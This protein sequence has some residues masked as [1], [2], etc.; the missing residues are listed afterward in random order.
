MF[1]RP[2]TGAES[3]PSA[4]LSS[5]DAEQALGLVRELSDRVSK[6]DSEIKLVE[7]EIAN[8][9]ELK[10]AGEEART[11]RAVVRKEVEE[12]I[13]AVDDVKKDIKVLG[14]EVG[15]VK[16]EFDRTREDLVGNNGGLAQVQ[17]DVQALRDKQAQLGLD[18]VKQDVK[19]VKVAAESTKGDL[20]G[21]KTELGGLSRD[22]GVVR[23]EVDKLKKEVSEKVAAAPT[24]TSATFGPGKRDRNGVGRGVSLDAMDVDDVPRPVKRAR[25]SGV[26]APDAPQPAV[27]LGSPAIIVPQGPTT[28]EM[29]N[30]I[31]EV[32]DALQSLEN[33][34]VQIGADV[35][36]RLDEFAVRLGIPLDEDVVY[37]IIDDVQTGTRSESAPPGSSPKINIVRAGRSSAPPEIT[38]AGP[39]SRRPSL[40]AVPEAPGGEDAVSMLRHDLDSLMGQMVKL[41]GSEGDWPATINKNLCKAL[42]VESLDMWVKKED[43]ERAMSLSPP[44]SA[45]KPVNGGAVKEEVEGSLGS[46]LKSIREDQASMRE[47]MEKMQRERAEDLNK[48]AGL[49]ERLERSE[50]ALKD[51]AKLREELEKEHLGMKERQAEQNR[52]LEQVSRGSSLGA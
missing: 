28:S 11:V 32:E 40:A 36:D 23:A 6:I 39:I 47:E 37:E 1:Y 22:L 10:K 27:P 14:D 52:L 19:D 43:T 15:R 8:M 4:P 29:L 48:M 49:I 41:W 21:V 30:R 20:Q 13:K 7:A 16:A 9:A 24:P 18:A 50:T 5:K 46:I 45:P 33:E 31:I 51:S 3:T 38:A 2:N 35:K 44:A 12:R 26:P 42:G 25:L 17:R 34:V